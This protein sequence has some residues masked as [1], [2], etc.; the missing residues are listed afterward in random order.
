MMPQSCRG[1]TA[2]C[3]SWMPCPGPSASGRDEIALN[4]HVNH[5]ACRCTR[6]AQVHDETKS[7]PVLSVVYRFIHNGW[8]ATC[9]Q[10]LRIAHKYWDMRDKLTSDNGL[11]FKCSSI[12]ILQALRESLLH[13]LHKKHTGIPKCQCMARSLIYWPGIDRVIEDYIKWY[14]ISIKL[15]P[16]L[17]AQPPINHDVPKDNGKR[18]VQTSW[19]W[20]INSTYSL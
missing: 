1:L 14:P 6:L 19:T 8:P 10:V 11:L 16:A 3:N 13:D 9:R 7:S 5:I 20:I 4:L 17:P 18:S 15:L 12:I 2:K